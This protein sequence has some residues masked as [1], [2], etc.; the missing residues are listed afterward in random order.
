MAEAKTVTISALEYDRMLGMLREMDS[1]TGMELAAL[2]R[3]Y[4]ERM[5]QMQR[6]HAA[7]VTRLE[8]VIAR[9]AEQLKEAVARIDQAEQSDQDGV[10]ANQLKKYPDGYVCSER[11]TGFLIPYG[12]FTTCDAKIGKE[13]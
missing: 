11:S 12:C 3:R 13:A 4:Q 9:Q 1:R 2:E 8:G 10:T 6:D 7:E 5:E